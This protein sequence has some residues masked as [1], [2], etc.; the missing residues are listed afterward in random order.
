MGSTATAPPA[1]TTKRGCTRKH[2]GSGT[3]TDPPHSSSRACTRPPLTVGVA[4][5]TKEGHLHHSLAPLQLLLGPGQESLVPAAQAAA[6]KAGEVDAQRT[7]R[8][9]VVG[10]QVAAGGGGWQQAEGG[11]SRRR[12]VSQTT[13]IC[14]CRVSSGSGAGLLLTTCVAMVPT[15]SP[16]P[17]QACSQLA[18]SSSSPPP[19]ERATSWGIQAPYS[20]MKLCSVHSPARG[21]QTVGGG[22]RSC[23]SAFWDARPAAGR[24]H[25]SNQQQPPRAHRSSHCLLQKRE[26][27]RLKGEEQSESEQGRRRGLRGAASAA[28]LTPSA[29]R[30][31][32]PTDRPT[33]GRTFILQ[34]RRHIQ[35]VQARRVG[36][37]RRRA[38]GRRPAAVLGVGSGQ[39]RLSMPSM[40]AERCGRSSAAQILAA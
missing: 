24:P 31:L 33:P 25:A 11:G 39:D 13:C 8:G 17:A 37:G 10:L 7:H 5:S 19:A 32:N 9:V 1:C 22:S 6:L 18:S 20:S 29:D 2:S 26:C 30:H 12:G 4:L 3:Q 28:G 38:G 16:H 40:Q 15:V 23:V 21:A 14:V 27:G 36:G 35:L 34:A